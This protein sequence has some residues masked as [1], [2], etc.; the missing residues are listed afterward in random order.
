MGMKEYLVSIIV[1]VYNAEKFIIETIKTV[2]NQTYQN[3]ELLLVNDYSTDKSEEI[4]ERF[5]VDDRIKLINLK[6]NL[7]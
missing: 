6:Q 7:E 2:Q 1:P 4:I 5:L 3:W